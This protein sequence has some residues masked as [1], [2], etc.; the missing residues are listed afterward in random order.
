MSKTITAQQ[1]AARIANKINSVER[2]YRDFTKS[3]FSVKDP[4]PQNIYNEFVSN[5]QSYSD[6]EYS[7]FVKELIKLVEA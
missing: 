2:K 4:L 1:L 6:E 7:V 5:F 3:D